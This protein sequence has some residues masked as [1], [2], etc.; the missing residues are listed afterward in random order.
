[1]L[2]LPPAVQGLRAAAGEEIAI[3]RW[4]AHKEEAAR[5]YQ[6]LQTISSST[7]TTNVDQA[8]AAL[9]KLTKEKNKNVNFQDLC[10]RLASMK[11]IPDGPCRQ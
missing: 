4:L 11:E 5:S 2:N 1:V 3:V 8:R 7:F 10:S 9:G 6:R